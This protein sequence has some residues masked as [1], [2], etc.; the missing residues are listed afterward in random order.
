MN[1]SAGLSLRSYAKYSKY[2]PG[3]SRTIEEV[4]Y[5]RKGRDGLLEQADNR[6][7]MAGVDWYNVSSRV[8]YARDRKDSRGLQGFSAGGCSY[9]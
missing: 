6:C 3:C 2:S 4:D 8:Q 5:I 9:G 1:V 7:M